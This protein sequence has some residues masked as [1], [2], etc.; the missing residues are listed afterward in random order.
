MELVVGDD[1]GQSTLLERAQEGAQARE[2][3]I[4]FGDDQQPVQGR[5]RD[6]G[7]RTV[8]VVHHVAREDVAPGPRRRLDEGDPAVLRGDDRDRGL[9]PVGST[10]RRRSAL[11]R[12]RA[13]RSV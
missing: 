7:P 10:I 13:R 12:R 8:H 6:A 1:E 11:A 5:L 9:R 4:R 2:T 3:R